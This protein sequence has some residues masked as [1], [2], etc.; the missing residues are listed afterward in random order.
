LIRDLRDVRLARTAVTFVFFAHGALFGTW[1]ARIP[2]IKDEV[3]LEH[4]V[5]VGDAPEGTVSLSDVE[6]DPDPDF[7]A[8]AA[9]R[10]G[11][12]ELQIVEGPTPVQRLFE[13]TGL[14]DRLPFVDA[15][16]SQTP[17]RHAVVTRRGAAGGEA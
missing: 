5:V 11:G 2:A 9:A 12:W 14:R 13:I 17:N 16:P 15:P 6:N 4:I 7:D 1:V 8:D 3:G 10:A